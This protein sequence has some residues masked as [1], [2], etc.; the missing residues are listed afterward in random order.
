MEAEF[1]FSNRHVVAGALRGAVPALVVDLGGGDVA[2]SEK[3]PD[4]ADVD[5]GV[6]EQ[7]GGGGAEGVRGKDAL[8]VLRAICSLD[9][10]HGPGQLPEVLLDQKVHGE[11][12]H[13]SVRQS[14]AA[15]VKPR[16]EEGPGGDPGVF[17]LLGDR[18]GSGVVEAKGTELRENVNGSSYFS[19]F[20]T[21]RTSFQ[22][23]CALSQLLDHP[24]SLGVSSGLSDLHKS[25]SGVLAHR[26]VRI[27]GE[28]GGEGGDEGRERFFRAP[29]DISECYGGLGAY[30][31][32]FV[33]QSLNL[34]L[35]PGGNIRII[36]ALRPGAAH[37]GCERSSNQR[38]K[39]EHPREFLSQ[40]IS[41]IPRTYPFH[42]SF[43]QPTLKP[44][45]LLSAFNWRWA[46]Q[47]PRAK[48]HLPGPSIS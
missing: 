10:L 2:V 26:G 35:N 31:E 20:F 1:V 3:I 22:D 16:P 34:D 13:G 21:E 6:E 45:A 33:L 27:F 38:D 32:I 47:N 19:C 43:R 15:R 24:C 40:A 30:G 14:P 11:R 18:L 48:F 7:R 36:C 28:G 17:D 8:G 46:M 25:Q 4:L 42:R 5:A 23:L 9:L 39:R 37:C 29:P 41:R 44:V 12:G